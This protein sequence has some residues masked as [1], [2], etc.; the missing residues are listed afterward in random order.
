MEMASPGTTRSSGPF[1][2]TFSL[3]AN[4]VLWLTALAALNALVRRWTPHWAF[5][6]AELL[7]VYVML[8][9]GSALASVDFPSFIPSSPACGSRPGMSAPISPTAPG[10]PSAGPPSPSILSPLAW[11]I[12]CPWTCF[13]RPGFSSS[14]GKRNASS[15]MYSGSTATAPVSPMWKSSVWEPTWPLL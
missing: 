7:T 13:F 5:S 6:S 14:G 8:C 11:A 2:T 1:P 9:L 12:C 10:A 3:F 15:A 4:V